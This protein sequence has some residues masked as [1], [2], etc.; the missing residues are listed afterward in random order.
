ML[1]HTFLLSLVAASLMPSGGLAQYDLPRKEPRCDDSVWPGIGEYLREQ[2]TDDH[3]GCTQL[4]AQ[5]VRLPFHDCFPDGGCD[6]SI[7]L[8][9]ECTSRAENQQMVPL[10]RMLYGIHHDSHIGAADLINFA[11][12]I[13]NKACPYGPFIPFY[14]GRRDRQYAAPL[15]Q[16]P[17][18][19]TSAKDM[20]N[21]FARKGFSPEDLVALTD[22]MDSPKYY[23]EV[24]LGSAPAILPS[25][26]HL[27]LDPATTNIWQL[28]ARSQYAWDQA[29]IN[30]MLKL[31]LKG[32]K[33]HEMLDCSH[34]VHETFEY[35][36][37]YSGPNSYHNPQAWE[38]CEE[39]A[40]VAVAGL[41]YG[42]Q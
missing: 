2:F 13:A 27:A 41:L 7:L 39:A 17:S 6:G 33:V 9:D 18:A 25:D 21:I 32:N 31:I 36:D 11:A 24:L 10:C 8:T 16:L 38:K 4:A 34:L 15:N 37:Q 35:D 28:Y 40:V 14:V 42:R 12:S 20:L 29:Y 30:G 22:E 5:A 1:G 3:G 26:K 23:T 19:T